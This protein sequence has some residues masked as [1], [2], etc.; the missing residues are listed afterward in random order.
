MP[1]TLTILF[2]VDIDECA[3]NTHDCQKGYDCINV[4][5]GFQ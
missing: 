3:V 2:S 5:G 1:T 4:L